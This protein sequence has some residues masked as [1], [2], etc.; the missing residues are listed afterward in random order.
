[1][2]LPDDFTTHP[3]PPREAL[4]AMA[5][6]GYRSG[7][8]THHQGAQLLGIDRLAFENLARTR[9]TDAEY[10]LMA[11]DEEREREATAWSEGLIGD[12]AEDPDAP[13]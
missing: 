1:M 11:N 5:I 6:D 3:D 13:R 7:A 10:R 2:H 8:L 9:D 4:E 12:A